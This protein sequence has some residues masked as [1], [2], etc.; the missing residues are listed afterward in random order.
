MGR[1]VAAA[2]VVVAGLLL[3]VGVFAALVG[4]GLVR[5]PLA[6]R[7]VGDL[8][9]AR[10]ERPGLR[11][12][13]VG[14]SLTFVNEMPELVHDL[15]A[16]DPGARPLFTVEYAAPNWTLAKAAGDER[17]RRLVAELE[18]DV[19]VLQENSNVAAMPA[20]RR[21]ESEPYAAALA[22]RAASVGAETVFYMTGVGTSAQS[23][24][25][26]ARENRG[27]VAPVG[28]AWWESARRRPGLD[29]RGWDGLHPNRAGS[30]LAACVFYALLSGRSAEESAFTA[31]LPF[32]D[33][34]YLQR[35][36][37]EIVASRDWD[38]A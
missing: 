18:W 24:L 34:R 10:S 1:L 2:A 9:L 25:A 28:L 29:L 17:L 33:A 3:G 31:G 23:T 21:T 30:Y 7:L 36:A 16:A 37:D 35:L 11:V 26:L 22:A 12:L 4:A 6:P 8:A 38:P 15:A 20:V 5:N 27:T 14:N 19:V 32:A 13:F